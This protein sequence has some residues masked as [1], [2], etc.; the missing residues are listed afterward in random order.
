MY[1]T[2][3]L[4]DIIH[5]VSRLVIVR[6]PSADAINTS[7]LSGAMESLREVRFLASLADPNICRVLGICTAEQ[8]PWT[9][10]EYGEMGNLAQYLQ[11]LANKNNSMKNSKDPSLR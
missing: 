9:I 4:D 2:E 5:D 6:I 11:F 8:P 1:E 3:N 10:I 7:S